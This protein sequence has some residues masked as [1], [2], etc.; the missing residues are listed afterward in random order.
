MSLGL[1]GW[2]SARL[3]FSPVGR[4]VARNIGGRS[5]GDGRHVPDRV[6]GRHPDRLVA[7]RLFVAVRPAADA[8]SHLDDF[9]D[10]RRAAAG[11]RWAS[12]EHFHVTLGFLGDVAD[13]QLDELVELLSS[14]ATRRTPFETRIAGGGAFP[15]VS[16]AKVLWAGLD[17]DTDAKGNLPNS[18]RALAVPGIRSAPGLTARPSSPTSRSPALG[19][20]RR[21]PTGS[22]SSTRTP[23]RPGRSPR[24]N[25]S[26]RT[27]ARDRASVPVTKSWRRCRWVEP[28][29]Q[30]RTSY[31]SSAMATISD[32]VLA[33]RHTDRG[34]ER[35]LR[36]TLGEFVTRA[37]RGRCPRPGPWRHRRA[38][39]S[40]R[41]RRA[42][43]VRRRT[44]SPS[45]A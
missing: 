34:P 36:M 29:S 8:A 3:G 2:V 33:Q 13:Y 21:C 24:S 23:G 42:G 15:N 40:S 20:R 41:G 18:P 6:P 16:A 38:S 9:L 1:A 27:S 5:A 10:V 17:L 43:S 26:P 7:V 37:E 12:A 30:R 35:P 25:S 32:D 44:R 39:G 14:A 19:D 11:F 45:S 28:R 4:A 22:G 31:G